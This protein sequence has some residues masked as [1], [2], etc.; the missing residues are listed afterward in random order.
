MADGD[1]KQEQQK[2][3]SVEQHVFRMAGKVDGVLSAIANIKGEYE[4]TIVQLNNVT[5]QKSAE[6]EAL[7]KRLEAAEQ[8]KKEEKGE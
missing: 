2:G 8:P 7:K 1:K 3:M 5:I 6:I 4:N